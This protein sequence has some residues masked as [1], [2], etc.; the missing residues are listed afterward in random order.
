MSR[1]ERRVVVM[2]MRMRVRRPE[3][4]RNELNV[5]NQTHLPITLPSFPV[6]QRRF[7]QAHPPLAR[8]LACFTQG[9]NGRSLLCKKAGLNSFDA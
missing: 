9:G 1:R 4:A 8:Q 7:R 3:G 2:M 5:R 6:S